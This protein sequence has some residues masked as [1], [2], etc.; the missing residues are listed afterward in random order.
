MRCKFGHVT[1]QNLGSTKPSYST[2]WQALEQHV[3]AKVMAGA[4]PFCSRVARLVK[5]LVKVDQTGQ[6][7][8]PD[9]EAPCCTFG[10]A[11]HAEYPKVRAAA[12]S[13]FLLC[14]TL[15]SPFSRTSLSLT[16]ILLLSLP[17]T[18]TQTQNISL[19]LSFS[20][21]LI[22]CLCLALSSTLWSRFPLKDTR[23][24]AS[25]LRPTH[26]GSLISC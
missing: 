12:F 25:E 1:H 14:I 22:L 9:Q 5:G 13:F 15:T 20:L 4:C 23:S 18:H 3:Y 10:C 17:H 7:G 21:P 6:S 24:S 11:P 2:V 26:A 19:S 8:P 16:Q